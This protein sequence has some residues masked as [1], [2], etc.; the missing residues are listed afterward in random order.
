MLLF[1]LGEIG[2]QV[3]NHMA[4][5]VHA[6]SSGTIGEWSTFPNQLPTEAKVGNPVGPRG[7]ASLKTED[8]SF[9]HRA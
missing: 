5:E 7:L 2:E 6:C 4:R 8:L 3:L 9:T 1:P